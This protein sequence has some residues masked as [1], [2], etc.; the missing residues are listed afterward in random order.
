MNSFT[1]LALSL[2]CLLVIAAGQASARGMAPEAAGPQKVGQV[3]EELKDTDA[4]R[5][6]T[7][8]YAF[9]LLRNGQ[10]NAT[11]ENRGIFGKAYLSGSLYDLCVAEA[12]HSFETPQGS[13]LEYLF[14]GSVWVGGIVDG[15]TLVSVAADGWIIAQETAP[16]VT[17][18]VFAGPAD[19]A[20]WTL[21][22]DTAIIEIPYDNNVHMPM[23]I[24]I[25][26]R[27]YVWDGAPAD[28]AIV[29]DMVI[30]N[31][32]DQTIEQGYAGLYFD[33]DV[34]HTSIASTGWNDDLTGSLRQSGIAYIIDNDGDPRGGVFDGT[35]PTK[36]FAFSF[37]QTS[38][39]AR[40]TSYNWWIPDAGLTYDFG[41]MPVDQYGDP[42]CS[43]NGSVGYPQGDAG[44][45]CIMS[46]PG[47]DYDQIFTD[48]VPGWVPP[49][50]AA[51]AH[52][53]VN[54][55]DTRF[56]MS[57]G[58]FDLMPDSSVRMLFTTFTGDSVHKVV[59]NSAN[60][61]DDPNQY[62]ANLDFSQVLAN[63]TVAKLLGTTVLDPS[64]AVTGLY[65][66]HN[67]Q[68]S[69]VVE[70]D[71]WGFGDV[72]GYDLYLY[73]VQSGD[74]PYPGV[75]PPWLKPPAQ[76]P[77][78]ALGRTYR[79]SF[80]SLQRYQPYLV[81]VAN[82]YGGATGD[83]GEPLIIQAGGMSPAP[84]PENE[85]V[86]ISQAKGYPI[87][88]NW[89][90]PPDVDVDY[91]GIYKFADP[92][93]AKHKYYPRYDT[94]QFQDSAAAIDSFLVGGV[95]Y[96]YYGMTP[97]AQVD[98]G[99]TSFSEL[100]DDS[101]VYVMT[102]VDKTGLESSFS[103]D[104]TVLVVPEKT[105]DILVLTCSQ[106]FNGNYVYP[107]T[108]ATFYQRVLQGYDFDI[109]HWRDTIRAYPVPSGYTLKTGW[110]YDLMRYRLVIVDDG[111]Q[112]DPVYDT[113]PLRYGETVSGLG[114]FLQYGGKLAYCGSFGTL[115]G[116]S[117]PTASPSYFA[118]D[119]PFV[120]RFF[121]VDSVFRIGVAYYIKPPGVPVW[122]SLTGMIEAV[123]MGDPI[124]NVGYDTL[125]NPF[126][127]AG[128][129]TFWPPNTVAS[130]SVYVVNDKGQ[131]IQTLRSRYP[132]TSLV[133]NLPVGVTTEIEGA[134]TYLYGYHL[135]YMDE[136][137]ARELVDYMMGDTTAGSIAATIIEPETM[138][139]M[140]ANAMD[141]QSGRVYVAYED[142]LYTVADV[143]PSSILVNGAITPLS[144]EIVSGPAI[145]GGEALAADI[146]LRPFVRG[147]G[148]AW[149]TTLQTY[150]VT[151]SLTDG[152]PLGLEGRFIL[153]GHISGDANG[154]NVVNI[155]DAIFVINYVFR[156]G[157]APSLEAAGDANADGAV[158]I[159][160]AVYLVHYIFRGGPRPQH[161]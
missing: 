63:A 14:S 155:G 112:S 48:T 123:A 55:Y 82:R 27:A 151:G 88:L 114:K 58:P 108:L 34:Y 11:I 17:G 59:N 57:V 47:W 30:T 146:D 105:E 99:M 45:Y 44:K 83:I 157:Q 147:Y 141:V 124:P 137:D 24:R 104:V 148:A 15:D 143:D 54:G 69:V 20:V 113:A 81:N 92:E 74:L 71:P 158:D 79:H 144:T 132:E 53:L 75:V 93:T 84:I 126:F 32:G 76:S 80:T 73:E 86:F 118:V 127:W 2:I 107:D 50:N 89:T 85:Y 125:Q 46:S 138:Y 139:V 128:S 60:L 23:N 101:T 156:D 29:Y 68:D 160:D 78:A 97:Y 10:I 31:I 16:V 103:K 43:F 91:Y 9:W 136:T 61:P 41:P 12:C 153:I 18:K 129:G 51:Y 115:H 66:Q 19:Y 70:W 13:E 26:N 149:D 5:A 95:R 39:P 102:A 62:L 154:D 42:Y 110:W 77:V 121:G 94:G 72:D 106:T 8:P 28:N 3:V 35:S 6:Q 135:W 111:F 161:P 116:F 7:P 131:T 119:H 100:A 67:D 90:A 152:T 22:A 122:D 133:N 56:L 120:Q 38:F 159:G 40:D 142:S 4:N 64:L 140:F 109:Y 134:V 65:T 96:Y 117:S 36:A 145:I 52:D 98:S 49:P 150:T 33:A 130:P 87:T 21:F 37:L 1:R 25:A